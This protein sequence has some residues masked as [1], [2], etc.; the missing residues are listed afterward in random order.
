MTSQNRRPAPF[1]RAHARW[2][3]ER[4]TLELVVSA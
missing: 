2:N 4:E 1:G 3:P